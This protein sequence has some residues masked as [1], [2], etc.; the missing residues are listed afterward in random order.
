MWLRL[1]TCSMMMPTRKWNM[2]PLAK[3]KQG[4]LLP[5]RSVWLRYVDNIFG[6]W[7]YP[8]RPPPGYCPQH[9]NGQNASILFTMER[10]LDGRIAFLDVRLERMG[11]T[12]HPSVFCKKIHTDRLLHLP[13]VKGVS[14]HMK[15]MCRPL[16]VRTVMRLTSTLRSSRVKV[17]QARPDRKKSV[18][19]E[20]PCKACPCVY[21][22]E[23]GRT[24]EKW[25]SEHKTAVKRHDTK[26]RIAVHSWTNQHQFDW[27]A[28]TVKHEERGYW[29]R[30]VLAALHS[31]QQPQTSNLDCGL[32]IN[33]SWLPL[34]DKPPCLWVTHWLPQ[35]LPSL[36]HPQLT[37]I[38]IP[39]LYSI[40]RYL[41][42]LHHS[43]LHNFLPYLRHSL[44]DT[45]I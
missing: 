40:I 6:I 41:P 12:A 29:K 9:L 11:T 25:L 10:E 43:T 26:N 5:W 37:L 34:L 27:D 32:T 44:T 45:L 23:M 7:P 4:S 17:K 22:G 3:Q 38:F 18:V 39:S 13:Y 14:E 16:G 15:K 35:H 2:T 21:I 28:A 36:P 33:L 31:Q 30:R 8:W 42:L 19:Y 20:V 1:R 24:L